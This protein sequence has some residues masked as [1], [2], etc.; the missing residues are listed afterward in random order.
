MPV[1]PLSLW[2]KSALMKSVGMRTDCA[3]VAPVLRRSWGVNFTRPLSATM[4]CTAL[5]SELRASADRRCW[6]KSNTGRSQQRARYGIRS[7]RACAKTSDEVLLPAHCAF[8]ALPD[9]ADL[10]HRFL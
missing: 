10:L 8:D 7:S 4:C 9:A 1:T 3:R 5:L 2:F 6:L